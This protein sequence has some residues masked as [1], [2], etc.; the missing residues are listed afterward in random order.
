M[1]FFTI[2]CLAIGLA[3]DAFA[4]SVSNGISY[5]NY[6]KNNIIL[7]AFSFGFFQGLMPILGFFTGVLLEEWITAVDHWI[8]L[9]FL[10][11]LGIKMIYDSFHQESEHCSLNAFSYKTLLLQSFATSIDALAVGI[12]FAAL[13]VNIYLGSS[14]IFIITFIFCLWGGSLGK[15]FKNSLSNY[16]T[17]FGGSILVLIGLRIFIEHVF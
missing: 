2:I 12:S 13:D 5:K 16:A 15:R 11:F 14:I 7:T 3:M 9:L 1:G 8:A 4:V 6:T 17:L 10:G